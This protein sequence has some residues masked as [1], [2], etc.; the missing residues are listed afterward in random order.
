MKLKMFYP[1][2]DIKLTRK[3]INRKIPQ[4]F[5]N[6]RGCN[7]IVRRKPQKDK[8]FGTKKETLCCRR[9]KQLDSKGKYRKN[10]EKLA[11]IA[12]FHILRKKIQT[13]LHAKATDVIII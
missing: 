9:G 12:L 5:Q 11:Y 10:Q 4:Q 13:K 3:G 2:L 1:L 7:E 6:A 8:L